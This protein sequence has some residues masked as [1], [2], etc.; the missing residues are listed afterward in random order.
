MQEFIGLKPKMFSIL[1]GGKQKLSAKGV[2]QSAQRKLEHGLYRQVL[3]TGQSFETLN[4]RIGSVNKELQT[5]RTRKGSL[6]LR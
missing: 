1:S 3:L 2:T 6:L 5:I 4:T